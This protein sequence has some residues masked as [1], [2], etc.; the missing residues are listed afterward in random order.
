MS[1]SSVVSVRPAPPGP[2]SGPGRSQSRGRR[3]PRSSR[4]FD[5]TP[6]RVGRLGSRGPGQAREWR[7]G[8]TTAGPTG[9]GRRSSRDSGPAARRRRGGSPSRATPRLAGRVPCT[10][11][12]HSLAGAAGPRPGR[13][14]RPQ[15]ESGWAAVV[16]GG[17]RVAAQAHRVTRERRTREGASFAQAPAAATGEGRTPRPAPL[18]P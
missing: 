4:S 17:R 6:P 10:P 18:P 8:A 15:I 16:R 1:E 2:S 11:A 3:G 13:L 5:S 12:R 7:R 9:A 14:R